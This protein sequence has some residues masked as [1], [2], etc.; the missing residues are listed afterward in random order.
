MVEGYSVSD[1]TELFIMDK[2]ENKSFYGVSACVSVYVCGHCT[3]L[4]NPLSLSS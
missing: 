4:L 3:Q 1:R 2:K